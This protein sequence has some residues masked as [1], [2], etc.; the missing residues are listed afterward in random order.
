MSV[1]YSIRVIATGTECLFPCGTKR[2]AMAKARRI[3]E[4][5]GYDDP[6]I[7]PATHSVVSGSGWHVWPS[8]VQMLRG[9][10]PAMQITR[11]RRS[12]QCLG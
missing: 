5:A 7:I 3:M 9:E 11:L 8:S 4:L 6:E 1:E 10:R 12:R 2:E